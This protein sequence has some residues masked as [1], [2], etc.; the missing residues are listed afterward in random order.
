M[1]ATVSEDDQ[2]WAHWINTTTATLQKKRLLRVLHPIAATS[3]AIQEQYCPVPRCAARRCGK[4]SNAQVAVSA[5]IL[6]PWQAEGDARNASLSGSQVD[7]ILLLLAST[8]SRR[9]PAQQMVLSIAQDALLQLFSLN[10]YLGLSTHPK[11]CQA[12][13]KAARATGMGRLPHKRLLWSICNDKTCTA[14]I[15]KPIY[16]Y[17]ASDFIQITVLVH[18]IVIRL[19]FRSIIYFGEPDAMLLGHDW[20]KICFNKFIECRT[21]LLGA[22]GRLYGG[23][24]GPGG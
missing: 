8:R 18:F 24:R 1:P 7:L 14:L 20:H 6:Q 19:H 4:R 22:G 15:C 3:S 21:P 2:A 10:D 11:V 16:R 13:A 9:T 12:A 23:A 17:G 5:E